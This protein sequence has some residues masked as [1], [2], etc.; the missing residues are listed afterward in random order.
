MIKRY[1]VLA[2]LLTPSLHAGKNAKLRATSP[3]F[4][5]PVLG[6]PVS[7]LQQKLELLGEELD[8][9]NFFWVVGIGVAEQYKKLV[10][11]VCRYGNDYPLRVFF[12]LACD[13]VVVKAKWYDLYT[14]TVII[15]ARQA[16]HGYGF[17]NT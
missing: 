10:L 2:C 9:M 12:K 1:L 16:L 15:R 11:E 4:K 13:V 6:H 17:E 14:A 8:K 5:P 7:Q 3:V